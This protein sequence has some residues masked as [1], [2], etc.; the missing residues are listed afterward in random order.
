MC[1][2]TNLDIQHSRHTLHKHNLYKTKI[3]YIYIIFDLRPF[4]FNSYIKILYCCMER[5]RLISTMNMV[6]RRRYFL[7]S[8]E[9]RITFNSMTTS[10][11]PKEFFLDF[12]GR[13]RDIQRAINMELTWV[14]DPY[15][16]I[17]SFVYI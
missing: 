9:G 3:I 5:L 4:S 6:L 1:V 13:K 2:I 15:N 16:F 11:I 17:V 10:T 12:Q 14:K 7:Y 8:Y